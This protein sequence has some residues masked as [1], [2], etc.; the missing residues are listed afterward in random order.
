MILSSFMLPLP[1]SRVVPAAVMFD[2]RRPKARRGH[3]HRN[4]LCGFGTAALG[5][6]LLRRGRSSLSFDFFRLLLLELLCLKGLLLLGLLGLPGTTLVKQ[7]AVE[8]TG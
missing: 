3:V 2:G 7:V 5:I 1:L 6:G 4:L 8:I